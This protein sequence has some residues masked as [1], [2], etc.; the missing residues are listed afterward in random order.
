MIATGF[1][2]S[3]NT[4][5]RIHSVAIVD[6]NEVV[7]EYSE[8]TSGASRRKGAVSLSQEINRSSRSDINVPN[9]IMVRDSIGS[10]QITPKIKQF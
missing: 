9:V 6:C 2:N 8:G 4:S 3:E 5:L 1:G 10:G 7:R